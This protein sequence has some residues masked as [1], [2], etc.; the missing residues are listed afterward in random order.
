MN[1]VAKLFTTH[2]ASVDES[3]LEHMAFAGKFSGRLFVAAFAALVHAVLPFL[4]ETT[5]SRIIRQLYERMHNR[6]TKA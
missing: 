4:F 5:A 1:R 6:A 3:Y 2:P